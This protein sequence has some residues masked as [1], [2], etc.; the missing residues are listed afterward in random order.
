[1]AE[2]SY[3]SALAP[4]IE[5]LVAAKRACGFSYEQV[6][7]NLERIDRFCTESG[8][9]DPVVT[10]EMAAAWAEAVPGEGGASRQSRMSAL[11][12]LSLHMRSL[13]MDA[14]VPSN[15]SSRERP[16]SYIPTAREVSA[17]LEAADSYEDPHSNTGHMAAGY[18]VAFRLMLCCG[19]RLSECCSLASRDFD[20]REGTVFIRHSKGDKD[21]LVYLAGDATDMLR[22]HLGDLRRRLGFP[23]AWVF[24][25]KD[26]ASH[27]AKGTLD[28]KFAQFWAQVPGAASHDRRPT[29]HSLRHAFV[30]NRMNAWMEAGADL[31]QMMPY[32]AAYLGHESS[33]ETF[34]YYHQVREAFSIV[35]QRDEIAPRVIPEVM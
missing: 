20:G 23:P 24:P 35:R 18:G 11:C 17:L 30:V 22:S 4:C 12:Q 21:R 29:P 25:G 8:F 34:Y 14:Y 10:R 6:A 19:L 13:G 5:G 1:M 3:S 31:G 7:Y 28:R 26:P 16:V 2:R 27:I 9:A 32:L 15:F 33:S